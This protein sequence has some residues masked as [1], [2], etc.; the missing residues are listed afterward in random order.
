MIESLLSYVVPSKQERCRSNFYL[1]SRVECFRNKLEPRRIRV[2]GLARK[3]HA[4]LVHTG[5]LEVQEG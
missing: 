3:I 2:I 4:R 1:D 5:R